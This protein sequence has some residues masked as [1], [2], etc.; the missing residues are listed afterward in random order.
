MSLTDEAM[1]SLFGKPFDRNGNTANKGKPAGKLLAK[2]MSHP[3]FFKKP[4]KSTGRETFGKDLLK[5]ILKGRIASTVPEDLIATLTHLTA[6]SIRDAYER[7]ILPE[8]AIDEVVLSGGGTKNR[9]LVDLLR[10]LFKPVKVNLSDEYGIP[11]EAKEAM[12]FAVLANE[13]L[14][15]NP[16][17]LTRVTGAKRRV[18]LG[19]IT[20]P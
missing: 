8:Y 13:T 9:Y 5:N 18:I 14:S 12:S 6:R 19:K 1:K 7:F 11:P 2:L 4:P 16:S 17:N 15:G 3:Y 20:L 10:E